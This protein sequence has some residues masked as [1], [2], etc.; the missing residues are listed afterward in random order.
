M[1][2]IQQAGYPVM[3][4][5]IG[6]S[7]FFFSGNLVNWQRSKKELK[8]ITTPTLLIGFPN[9]VVLP[10]DYEEWQNNLQNTSYL[11]CSKG[12]HLGWWDAPEEIFSAIEFFIKA[13]EEG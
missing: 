4:Q 8:N 5:M 3:Q 13:T 6:L 9:D 1:Q 2:C 12:G 7:P 11:L 10:E